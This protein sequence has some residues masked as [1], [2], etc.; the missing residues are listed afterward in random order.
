MLA[1]FQMIDAKQISFLDLLRSP[2]VQF[3]DYRTFK[4][5]FWGIVNFR[6]P[7]QSMNAC[8]GRLYGRKE[9]MR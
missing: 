1:Y 8:L 7:F 5:P 2:I 6:F 4:Y 3:F 9:N